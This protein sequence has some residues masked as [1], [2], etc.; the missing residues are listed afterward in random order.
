MRWPHL[1]VPDKAK[2]YGISTVLKE[3]VDPAKDL[4]LQVGAGQWLVHSLAVRR[5]ERVGQHWRWAH[6]EDLVLQVGAG[7]GPFVLH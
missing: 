5:C 2:H 7:E 1:Q 4:V 6:S 3:A